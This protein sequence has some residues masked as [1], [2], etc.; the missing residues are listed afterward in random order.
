MPTNETFVAELLDALPDRFGDTLADL[1]PD[2]RI[3]AMATARQLTTLV[4]ATRASYVLHIGGE[5]GYTNLHI[6]G[7]FGHTGQLEIVVPDPKVASEIERLAERYAL[8]ERL[9]VH[10]GDAPAVVSGLNGPFD[11]I[12]LSGRWSDYP[13]LLEDLA[14]LNRVGGSLV[15]ANAAELPGADAE[16]RETVAL[17]S[18]LA[19]LAAD[20]RYLLST[21]FDFSTVLAARVR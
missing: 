2:A 7:A 13:R 19:R 9:S 16:A 11:L 17:R 4:R 10:P 5:L 20:E 21:G 3:P 6:A 12:V 15:V 8:S 14:R 1:P 18:V